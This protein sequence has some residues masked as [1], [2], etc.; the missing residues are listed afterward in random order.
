MFFFIGGIQPKTVT[1]DENPRICPACGR[2]QLYLK[3]RDQY[4]SVFF[5]PLFPLKK[6]PLLLICENCSSVFDQHG[7]PMNRPIDSKSNRK[8]P[9]CG[10]EISPAFSFCPYCGNKL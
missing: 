9:S 2:Y 1:L 7:N 6:G 4:L 8:C 5:I 10:K 3:R